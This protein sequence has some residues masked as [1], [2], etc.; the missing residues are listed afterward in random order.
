MQNQTPRIAVVILNYNG[1][2]YLKQFLP[3][4]YQTQYPNWDL[5][6]ADNAST[7]ASRHFLAEEGFINYNDTQ[8][9][10]NETGRYLITMDENRGYAGGYNEALLTRNIPADVYVLLN[11]DVE[12]SPSWLE[13]AVEAWR[14]QPNW[15]A[16]QPK[17]LDYKRRNYFEAA[18]AGGGLLDKWV[19]PFCRGRIFAHLEEDKGQYDDNRNIFWAT[20]AALFIKKEAFHDAN[21]FD[22]DYFAHVEEID[23]CW[24]L[25]L[26]GGKIGYCGQSV[27]WHIGGGTLTVE[28]PRKTYLNFRNSLFTLLKNTTGAKVFWLVWL[29][30]V[31][32]GVASAKFLL[33]GQFANIWAI[34][35]AHWSF[36]WQV[37]K[38]LKKRKIIQ[39]NAK[40]QAHLYPKSIVYQHF[41]KK[42]K[43]YKDLP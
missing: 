41:V 5:Y 10:T 35:R 31:L 14:Q 29:R 34:I 25:Q 23:L 32:D 17:I 19:Y 16:L 24:R 42:I 28:N 22:A 4:L 11:S 3:F 39:Q 8:P 2:G 38:F 26:Q 15:V 33:A 21:G 9:T 13:K 37:P 1:V 27:V 6:V 18:G 36:F 43:L 40:T 12:V 20:G 7:D 30:L